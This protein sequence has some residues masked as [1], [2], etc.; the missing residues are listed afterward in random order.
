MASSVK[1]DSSTPVL[2]G[3]DAMTADTTVQTADDGAEESASRRRRRRGVLVRNIV[4]GELSVNVP[5]PV[6]QPLVDLAARWGQLAP[7]DFGLG[8][9]G[10]FGSAIESVLDA[11]SATARFGMDSSPLLGDS[12]LLSGVGSATEA[13]RRF[14]EA[15]SIGLASV[16]TLPSMDT[17]SLGV[18]GPVGVAGWGDTATTA[19]AG[20]AGVSALDHMP[21]WMDG[22][23]ADS[24]SVRMAVLGD[25]VGAVRAF[26]LIGPPVLP[27]MFEVADSIARMS[28]V[29]QFDPLDGLVLPELTAASWLARQAATASLNIEVR[30]QQ[31]MLDAQRAAVE[32]D[33]EAVS[34]FLA[35]WTDLPPSKWRARVQ[36]GIDVLLLEPI[37]QCTSETAFDMLELLEKRV[38][39][40]Y[41]RGRVPLGE[42]TLAG[43]PI[44]HFE[45]LPAMTGDVRRP[46]EEFL[47][48]SPSAEDRAVARLGPIGDTRLLA[49]MGGM[50]PTECA[51]MLTW[52]EG[53]S[54]PQAAVACGLPPSEGE[55]VRAKLKRR[56]RVIDR[57]AGQ[58]RRR[59]G[60]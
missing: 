19:W 36:A 14:A 7:Q 30:L 47:P 54:W 40:H 1:L 42:T 53:R 26:D 39:R 55:R 59:D 32:G 21:E 17:V 13:V 25:V 44:V 15:E 6:G 38:R 49:V 28:A 31:E 46:A 37:E 18:T 23:F 9:V 2:D 60:H 48:V 8:V 27:R 52:G 57:A 3:D 56:S 45:V 35:K 22:L 11:G 4:T 58:T 33:E 43:R 41:Q 5:R 29:D 50:T 12:S 34:L 51:V 16:A 10:S 24:I 20:L